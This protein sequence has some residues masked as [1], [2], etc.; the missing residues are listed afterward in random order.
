M[1]TI[2]PELINVTGQL[3]RRLRR[4]QRDL[5]GDERPSS[6]ELEVLRYIR[7]HPGA[8]VGDV[9]SAL[10][11]AP[12]TLSTIVGHLTRL[13]LAQRS[14]DQLDKRV[15]HLT[16]TEAGRNLLLLQRDHRIAIVDAAL[17]TLSDHDLYALRS[18]LPALQALVNALGVLGEIGSQTLSQPH[19]TD[20]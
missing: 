17:A 16:L 1:E 2:A 11:Q 10:G 15:G 18:A 4:R 14:Q 5:F 8:R 20:L 6:P 12:N 7:D 3:R 19:G 13:G 9:A